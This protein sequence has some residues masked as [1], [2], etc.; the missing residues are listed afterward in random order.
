MNDRKRRLVIRALIGAAVGLA[1]ALFGVVTIHFGYSSFG[2]GIVAIGV[3][4]GTPGFASLRMRG[5]SA[6]MGKRGL[7]GVVWPKISG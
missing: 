6:G 7:F 2:T 5:L 1:I 3:V 4:G